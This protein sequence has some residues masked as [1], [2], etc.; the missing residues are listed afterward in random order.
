MGNTFTLDSLREETER[1]FAPVKIGL[2]DG[3]EAT[4]VS[5]LRLGK[6]D[7]ESVNA[8]LEDLNSVEVDEETDSEE[9]GLLIE[10]LSKIFT[11]ITD[12]SEQL[13]KE[14]DGDDL[15]VKLT[16]MIQV[17]HKWMGATQL[18]EAGNSPS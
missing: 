6:K 3:S 11:I 13:L 12:K 2:S 4:M 7:R 14:I 5:L 15:L 18:G 9:L 10:S 1:Q 16:L 17:L 8:T